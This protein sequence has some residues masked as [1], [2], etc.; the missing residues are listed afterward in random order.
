MLFTKYDSEINGL[1]NKKDI[2]ENEMRNCSCWYGG[3]G[4]DSRQPCFLCPGK[5]DELNIINARL[6]VLSIKKRRLT[7]VDQDQEEGKE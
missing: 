6:L 3:L 2:L 4:E 5:I 1:K 7:W